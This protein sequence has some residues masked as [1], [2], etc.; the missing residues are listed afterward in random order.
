MPVSAQDEAEEAPVRSL[1][2]PPASMRYLLMREAMGSWS[3]TVRCCVL[4][5]CCS[6]SVGGLITLAD[7]LIRSR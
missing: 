6:V 4:M 3:K 1:V 2:V 5:L 7:F